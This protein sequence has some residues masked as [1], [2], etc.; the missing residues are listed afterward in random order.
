MLPLVQFD[1]QVIAD[2]NQIVIAWAIGAAVVRWLLRA[3][4]RRFI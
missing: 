1:L 4:I 2:R 3:I